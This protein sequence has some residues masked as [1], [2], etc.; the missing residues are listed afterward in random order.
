MSEGSLEA[1]LNA[2]AEAEPTNEPVL[3]ALEEAAAEL[4]LRSSTEN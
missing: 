4:I 1:R 3:T 2:R